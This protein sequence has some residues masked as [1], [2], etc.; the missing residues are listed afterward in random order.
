MQILIITD[1]I[2]KDNQAENSD[3]GGAVTLG[4]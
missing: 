3:D 2:F 4:N 1:S